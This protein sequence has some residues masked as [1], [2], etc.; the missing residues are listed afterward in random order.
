MM[1]NVSIR[2]FFA[3]SLFVKMPQ[4]NVLETWFSFKRP[5]ND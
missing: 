2:E 4:E 5:R 1:R 3:S